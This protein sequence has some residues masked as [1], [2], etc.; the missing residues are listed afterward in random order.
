MDL[1]VQEHS[2]DHKHQHVQMLS[3]LPDPGSENPA[4]ATLLDAV[5]T[6]YHMLWL[7]GRAI[8]RS[9]AGHVFRKPLRKAKQSCR[10]D[11][12]QDEAQNCGLLTKPSHGRE[13]PCAVN[14]HVH[15]KERLA[16]DHTTVIRKDVPYWI[17]HEQTDATH[18]KD[19]GPIA[20]Q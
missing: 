3:K 7:S 8:R 4:V 5:A 6:Q 20:A 9:T 1:E 18:R 12:E 11:G 17:N 16:A 13:Y 2:I 14:S 10:S 15:C 19:E